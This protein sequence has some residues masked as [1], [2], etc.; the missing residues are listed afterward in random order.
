MSIYDCLCTKINKNA[1]NMGADLMPI[2]FM[3]DNLGDTQ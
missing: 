2:I 1:A 3:F